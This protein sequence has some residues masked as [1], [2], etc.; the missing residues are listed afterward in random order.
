MWQA[1]RAW[2]PNFSICITWPLPVWSQ[3][4]TK[5]DSSRFGRSEWIGNRKQA[6]HHQQQQ[7]QRLIHEGLHVNGT[8]EEIVYSKSCNCVLMHTKTAPAL[9]N[10]QIRESR[11]NQNNNIQCS[12]LLRHANRSMLYCNMGHETAREL[13]IVGEVEYMWY[14]I[15]TF[16]VLGTRFGDITVMIFYHALR[17]S[18]IV[19]IPLE[20]V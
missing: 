2:F 15:S 8:G 19:Q 7:A 9:S 16:Y 12:K 20:V 18:I 3:S 17:H 4:T 14:T 11:S 5:I 6:H 13:E 10:R 1:A